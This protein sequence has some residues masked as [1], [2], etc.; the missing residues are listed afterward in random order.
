M[1]TRVLEVPAGIEMD[2]EA[3]AKLSDRQKQNRIR[4]AAWARFRAENDGS[5]LIAPYMFEHR[6]EHKYVEGLLRGCNHPMADERGGRC[7]RSDV[8]P[9]H[10]AYP[11]SYNQMGSG[12]PRGYQQR[13]KHWDDLF[14][15]LLEGSGMPKGVGR[16]MVEATICVPA[17]RDRDKGNLQFFADKSLG[18]ALQQ[19]GWLLNDSWREYDF[20][21]YGMVWSPGEAWSRFQL[22]PDW[23]TP[24]W[25]RFALGGSQG[26]LL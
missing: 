9:R 16:V 2:A 25:E 22:F 11:P 6:M 20:G 3:W 1:T 14:V 10:H 18:D 8:H 19:G 4:K 15:M 7:G 5:P 23:E 24:G 21:H 26:A 12:D 13:K 17:K